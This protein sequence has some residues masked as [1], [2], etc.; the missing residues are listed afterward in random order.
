MGELEYWDRVKW[1]TWDFCEALSEPF[2][3]CGICR[4][5]VDLRHFRADPC[6]FYRVRRL[7]EKLHQGC[8]DENRSDW[9]RDDWGVVYDKYEPAGYRDAFTPMEMLALMAGKESG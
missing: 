7:F 4:V 3:C 1:A 9:G 6:D 5:F 2:A 8:I